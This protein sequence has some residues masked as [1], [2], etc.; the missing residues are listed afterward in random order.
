MNLRKRCL[1]LLLALML[2]LGSASAVT[3]AAASS[4][5]VIVNG[6]LVDYQGT[7]DV[8]NIP[9]R[10]TTIGAQAFEGNEYIEEVN[11]GSNVT[12]IGYKAFAECYNLK[13]INI[14]GSIT[15]I[16]NSCFE[17]CSS[18]TYIQLPREMTAIGDYAFQNCVTLFNVEGPD[19]AKLNGST[20]YPLS[21]HIT[22]V[23]TGAF[24]HCPHVVVNCFMGSAVETYVN[25]NNIP[26]TTLAPIIY[27]MTPTAPTPS[28]ADVP[29]A[30]RERIP[31]INLIH[32]SSTVGTAYIGL[33]I[34]PLLAENNELGYSSSNI[35]VATVNENGLVTAVAPG[36]CVVTV[37]SYDVLGA[38]TKVRI[39]VLNPA[40]GFQNLYGS[41][42]YC[43]N[44]ATFATGW[45]E[46]RG[47]TYYFSTDLGIMA[48]KWRTISGYTYY[49]GSNGRM[50]TGWQTISGVR[51]YFAGTGA[52]QRGWLQ[53]GDYWY[54][55]D[56]TGAMQTGFQTVDN[57][58]Y[59]FEPTNPRGPYKHPWGAM[60]ANGTYEI[61][62]V[63][64]TFD[65][66]GV[67][68]QV[69]A[70][71]W[72]KVGGK[73]YYYRNG[74]KVTG[75]LQDGQVWYYLNPKKDGAMSTGWMT[76]DKKKFYFGSDG[77][78]R[79]GW[80][81]IKKEWYYFAA[82]GAMHRGWLL[83]DGNYYYLDK[84]GIMVTGRYVIDGVTYRFASNGVLIQ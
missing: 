78:M 47:K 53:I 82:N 30:K 63:K 60:Y 8:V 49:F 54:L 17:S 1:S 75:W 7:D 38:T 39:N 27:K 37:Y 25:S 65:K 74:V 56:S 6:V 73:Y 71:G 28:A 50:R 46:I 31:Q 84:D 12:S 55:F 18:L 42:Y 34:D 66:S 79:T 58:L 10:V 44:A 24:N 3:A 23:G 41:R 2:V 80:A 19:A 64:Y 72:K 22:S 62:G 45:T 4:D 68:K 43:D 21:A 29:S 5:F 33:T 51:Y 36:T 59:Y 9:S 20:Y 67:A 52:M 26:H 32:G 57:K 14:P 48:K 35:G 40:K 61:N 16:P 13:E 11:I 76:I 69:A 83:L 77:K 70:N 15:K 81:K